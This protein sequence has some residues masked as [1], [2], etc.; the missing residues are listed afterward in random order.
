MKKL[1]VV[2]LFLTSICFGAKPFPF[3]YYQTVP[4]M[5]AVGG[6]G[7]ISISSTAWKN[8]A[9][10]TSV[11]VTVAP[12]AG[13]ACVVVVSG[14]QSNPANHAVSDN[15]SS[16]TG[17]VNILSGTFFANIGI[18]I[19]AKYSIASGVTTITCTG[20]AGSGTTQGIVHEVTG[21]TAFTG[22][23]AAFADVGATAAPATTAKTNATAA[24]IFFGVVATLTPSGNPA[25]ATINASGTVGTWALADA[26]H[27]QELDADNWVV[28]SVVYQIVASGA[29]RSHTWTVTSAAGNT[30]IAIFH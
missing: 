11:A 29:S 15:I 1:L 3:M 16:T 8:S 9:A 6:G 7:G 22:G 19:W 26:T 18:S 4:P 28:T 24:S 2:F 20:G 13:H 30:G 23:E 21:I 17:W 14:Y 25:T 5:A 10:T 27:S 12:T